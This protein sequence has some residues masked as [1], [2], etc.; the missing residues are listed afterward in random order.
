MLRD[1]GIGFGEKM[2]EEGT[3]VEVYVDWYANN[4][5]PQCEGCSMPRKIHGDGFENARALEIQYSAEPGEQPPRAF[6]SI[7]ANYSLAAQFIVHVEMQ[8]INEEG[9]F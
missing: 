8:M 5:I 6:C 9:K 7:M 1:E 2:R 3:R 4:A